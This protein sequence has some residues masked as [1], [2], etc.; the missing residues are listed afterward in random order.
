M[1]PNTVKFSHEGQNYP[2]WRSP[3]PALNIVRTGSWLVQESLNQKH[4][5]SGI[6]DEE[7]NISQVSEGLGE[8][9]CLMGVFP[10]LKPGTRDIFP[11]GLW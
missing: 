9:L 6:G 7:R 4:A 10:I 8:L 11:R 2:Q 5:S 1:S 3:L